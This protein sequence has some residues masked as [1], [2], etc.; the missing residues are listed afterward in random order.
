MGNSHPGLF[1]WGGS[2]ASHVLLSLPPP[3]L[4]MLGPWIN[5]S[6]VHLCLTFIFQYIP[7]PD[8]AQTNLLLFPLDGLLRANSVLQTL[9]LLSRPGVSPLLVQSPLFHFI[10]GM[11]ASAGGGL[12]GGTL[13]LTSETWTFSTPP[14][15]RTGVFGLWSTH[16]MWAGGIVAVIYGSLTSHPAFA[17][18]LSVTLSTSSARASSVAVMIA[19]FGARAFATRPKKLVQPPKEKVKTQ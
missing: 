11:T 19:F 17:N 6:A 5:Y 15:L 4:Y 7:V 18:V 2:I 1:C 14:P 9:S 16:D 13:S 12:L 3:Q 8:P 10:L